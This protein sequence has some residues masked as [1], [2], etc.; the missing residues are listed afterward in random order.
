L[1]YGEVQVEKTRATSQQGI[2]ARLGSFDILRE[3][4]HFQV[5][6]EQPLIIPVS[7]SFL[8]TKRKSQTRS[9]TTGR[10]K[11]FPEI[12]VAFT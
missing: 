5:V 11:P 4:P 12:W 9:V 10:V 8:A 2:P 7:I 6:P 3:H 1:F